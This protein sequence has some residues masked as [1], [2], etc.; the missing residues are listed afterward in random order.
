[1]KH[2]TEDQIQSCLDAGRD[3]CPDEIALHL[4][5]CGRCRDAWEEQRKLIDCLS[6]EPDFSLPD[7]FADLVVASVS[8]G[9]NRNRLRIFGVSMIAVGVLLISG[10]A[11]FILKG[12][13]LEKYFE[14]I[15]SLGSAGA[16]FW[17]MLDF[18]REWADGLFGERSD[19]ALAAAM[20]LAIIALADRLIF[21]PRMALFFTSGRTIR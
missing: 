12:S 5:Q 20:V 19:L 16:R 13:G 3:P 6:M 17:A 2:L 11:W 7:G 4:K 9:K 8:G 1:M 21:K 18:A 10:Y 14:W 15:K